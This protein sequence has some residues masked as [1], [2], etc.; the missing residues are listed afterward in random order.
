MASD[1]TIVE[2]PRPPAGRLPFPLLILRTIGNPVANW[3][4]DF[5]DE[6]VV[7]YRTFGLETVFVMDPELIQQVLLDDAE[8]FTKNS[9]GWAQA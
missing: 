9:K 6:P 2:V 1:A 8:S 3:A 4:Q 5:Y 7:V